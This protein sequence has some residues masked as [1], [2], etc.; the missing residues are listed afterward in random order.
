MP[1]F[2]NSRYST[3]QSTG[4]F[5]R[6]QGSHTPSLEV[7]VPTPDILRH[8][9]RITVRKDGS[10]LYAKVRAGTVNNLVPN[11]DG[12]DLDIIPAPELTLTDDA[13]NQIYLRAE[14][15]SPPVFFPNS[16]EVITSTSA[17]TDTNTYGYLLIGSVVLSEGKV[18]AINQYVYAS[19]VVVRAKPGSATALWNW[20]SR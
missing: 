17:Q 9:F 16:L 3:G 4:A 15:T 19:Q 1:Q 5:V 14:S 18:Q 13:T 7:D 2:P 8:P 10:N 12:D 20:S 6:A 11:I